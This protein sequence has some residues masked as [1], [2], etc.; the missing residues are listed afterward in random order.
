MFLLSM[1]FFIPISRPT[2]TR[3]WAIGNETFYETVWFNRLICQRFR[4]ISRKL[5][6]QFKR[7][8]SVM[9]EY[10]VGE[11]VILDPGKKNA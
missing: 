7:K 10:Q 2:L 8:Y 9:T 1:Y 5:Q 6:N 11:E 4:R 3:E